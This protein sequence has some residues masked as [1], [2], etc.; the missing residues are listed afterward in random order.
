MTARRTRPGGSEISPCLVE[1]SGP[2]V[3]RR[4]PMPFAIG[5]A[6]QNPWTARMAGAMREVGIASPL[7]REPAA[8]CFRM[9]DFIR[10]QPV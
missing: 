2:H 1:H 6:E 5:E 4:R 10:S 9:V 3:G 8:A 7:R